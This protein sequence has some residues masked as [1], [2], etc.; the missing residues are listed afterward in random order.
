VAY[1]EARGLRQAILRWGLVRHRAAL[2]GWSVV[3]VWCWLMLAL[4]AGRLRAG[5]RLRTPDQRE[6]RA[7]RFLPGRSADA[8]HVR[9]R[10]FFPADEFT[11]RQLATGAPAARQ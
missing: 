7:K 9:R 2:L 8:S 4:L 11:G 3:A 5:L 10:S 6:F 1:T